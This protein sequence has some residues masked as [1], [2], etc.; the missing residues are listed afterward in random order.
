MTSAGGRSSKRNQQQFV[1]SNCSTTT[2]PL[3]RRSE[4]GEPLCNACGLYLRLHGSER[5]V[6]MRNDVIKKR[7]R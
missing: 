6:E 4:A 7:N 3:W 5:P 2:T 1:C